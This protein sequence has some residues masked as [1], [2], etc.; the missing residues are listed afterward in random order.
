[1]TELL[2]HHRQGSVPPPFLLGLVFCSTLFRQ[3][4]VL[5]VIASCRD[6]RFVAVLFEELLLQYLR[7]QVRILRE[8]FAAF[9]EK[10]KDGIGLS[11]NAAVVKHQNRDSAIRVHLLEFSCVRFSGKDVDMDPFVFDR[12]DF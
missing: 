10:V 11:E 2:F 8:E 12:E 1:M 7:A 4:Q 3:A 9:G 5:I 6:K